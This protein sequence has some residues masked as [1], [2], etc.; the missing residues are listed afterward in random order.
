MEARYAD[1]PWRIPQFELLTQNEPQPDDKGWVKI[2]ADVADLPT[3][4]YLKKTKDGYRIDW[5]TSVGYNPVSPEEFRATLSTSPVRF[6]VFATLSD[7]YFGEFNNSQNDVWSID[8]RDPVGKDIGNG[9]VRK[10]TPI[11]QKLFQ[12]LKDGK[13]RRMV[14]QVQYLPKAQ[15]SSAFSISEV[16]NFEGWWYEKK[17]TAVQPNTGSIRR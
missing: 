16:I 6:R 2:E 8:L 14:V 1:N 13:K 9:Y 10:S 17:E 5:E 11:G 15:N 12:I 7:F 4:Y 3:A